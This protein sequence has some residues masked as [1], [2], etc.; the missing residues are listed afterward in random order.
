MPPYRLTLD[1]LE[2]TSAFCRIAPDIPVGPPMRAVIP[3]G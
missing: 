1:V 2:D 3:L